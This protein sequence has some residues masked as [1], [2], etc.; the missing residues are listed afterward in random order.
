MAQGHAEKRPVWEAE[1]GIHLP[2][3]EPIK[4]QGNQKGGTK[5]S[6]NTLSDVEEL[7]PKTCP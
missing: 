2:D 6:Y 7:K 3:A 1:R 4:G 5:E